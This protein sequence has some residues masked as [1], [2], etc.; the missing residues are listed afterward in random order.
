MK[1]RGDAAGDRRRQRRSGR[2]RSSFA[3]APRA[4]EC[5]SAPNAPLFGY[6]LHEGGTEPAPDSVAS[7]R[8][9][10]WS[11]AASR[12]RITVV[13]RLSEPTAVHWH[14]IELESYYD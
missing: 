8:L 7:P 14:G 13:N 9:R 4:G 1:R 12:V 10:W 2:C 3:A 5:G 6:A 11:C